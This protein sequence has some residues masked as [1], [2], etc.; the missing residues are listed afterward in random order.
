LNDC[1]YNFIPEDI[2]EGG[3]EMK[4]F[5]N[6]K[7]K[8]YKTMRIFPKSENRCS[9]RWPR[10]SQ[11]LNID[12]WKDNYEVIFKN[13]ESNKKFLIPTFLKSFHGAPIWN[14]EELENICQAFNIVGFSY[15]KK[16]FPK[17]KYLKNFGDLGR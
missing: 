7:P 8:H 15:I 2:T 3:I 1:N 4:N 14:K 11:N 10:I 17:K 5:P 6:K 13:R 12:D 9:G 16:T